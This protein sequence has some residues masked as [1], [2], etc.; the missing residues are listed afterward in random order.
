MT[1]PFD[2]VGDQVVRVALMGLLHQPFEGKDEVVGVSRADLGAIEQVELIAFAA[3]R[4]IRGQQAPGEDL[5]VIEVFLAEQFGDLLVGDMAPRRGAVDGDVQQPGNGA[6]MLVN[7]LGEIQKSLLPRME[8]AGGD[9]LRLH[10]AVLGLAAN[11]G[12]LHLQC[13]GVSGKLGLLQEVADDQPQERQRRER[14]LQER[15]QGIGRLQRI[16]ADPEGIGEAKPQ[17]CRGQEKA[18]LDQAS[19]LR[20][21]FRSRLGHHCRQPVGRRA[22]SARSGGALR[23]CRAESRTGGRRCPA[24]DR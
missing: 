17:P 15:A 10:H 21:R 19:R 7:D 23:R 6:E 16:P 14:P 22:R 9:G 8:F 1:R 5:V 11:L 12:Q 2:R 24:A 13:V 18:E 4:E 3:G 20:L